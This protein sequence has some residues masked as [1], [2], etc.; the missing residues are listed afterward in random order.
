MNRLE[1]W[2]WLDDNIYPQCQK[3]KISGFLTTD[4]DLLTVAEF[5]KTYIFGKEIKELKIR[6]SGDTTYQLY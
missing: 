6:F 4:D 1:K 5:S 2:I 3:T